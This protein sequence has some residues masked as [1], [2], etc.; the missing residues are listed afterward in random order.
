MA[1]KEALNAH[2][3]LQLHKTQVLKIFW[4]YSNACANNPMQT[5]GGF[6]DERCYEAKLAPKRTTTTL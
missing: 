5:G 6:A 3:S 4:I 2:T 1:C